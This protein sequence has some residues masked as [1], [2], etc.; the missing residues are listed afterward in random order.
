MGLVFVKIR[1]LCQAEPETTEQRCRRS[2]VVYS[3]GSLTA[4]RDTKLALGI[5]GMIFPYFCNI[6]PSRGYWQNAIR[7]SLLHKDTGVLRRYAFYNG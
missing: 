4:P 5:Q 1:S 3:A 7:I 6:V 2:A